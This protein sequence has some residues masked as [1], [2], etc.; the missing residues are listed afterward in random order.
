MKEQ[1]DGPQSSL[2]TCT[3]ALWPSPL[4]APCPHGDRQADLVPRG[5]AA[6]SCQAGEP[7]SGAVPVAPA[8]SSLALAWFFGTQ[9]GLM[10]S[11]ATES[12]TS[13]KAELLESR[14]RRPGQKEASF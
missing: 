8:P 7:G 11:W 6:G 9:T 4:V 5:R 1:E 14:G 2:L 13:K 3:E 10:S 12:L